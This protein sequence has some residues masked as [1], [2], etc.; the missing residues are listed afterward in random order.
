MTYSKCLESGGFTVEQGELII[1]GLSAAE[2]AAQTGTPVYVYSQDALESTLQD[3]TASFRSDHFDCRVVYASKAFNTLAMLQLA[4]KYHAGADV[5]SMGELLTALAARMPAGDIVFH[6]NNKS[7]KEIEAALENKIGC[8]VC[9]NLDEARRIAKAAA[10]YPESGCSILLR[11][12]PGVEAHTHS[13]IVTAHV[14]SKFGVLKTDLDTILQI[15][16]AIDA[17]PGISFNGFHAH[18]GSQI[19]DLEAFRSEIN[20]MCTFISE[21]EKVSGKTASTLDLGGGFAAFYTEEDHPI[22]IETVCKDIIDT[23]WKACQENGIALKKL[24]IEPGRS[25]VANAGLTLYTLSGIK[26]TPNKTWVFAD[27]GMNDNIR[28]ALYEAEYSCDLANRMDEEK[29]EEVTVAGKCCESGDILVPHAALP[30]PEEGD[31]LAVYTTGA[32]GYAMASHYN[33]LPVPGVVFVKD[34]KIQWV[35]EPEEPADLMK[36]ERKLVL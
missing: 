10:K 1:G 2:I 23:T 32:Y 19:F 22:P 35:V 14:D 24:W 36:R 20:V 29:T 15:A 11:I 34:G 27:G 17:A 25:I 12:N 21:Y 16:N 30:V 31:L 8:I 13:Y 9:D 7:E 6:G 3:Y 33:K 4:A 18:I 28:P 5:V 26:H